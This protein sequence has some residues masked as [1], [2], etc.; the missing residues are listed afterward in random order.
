[1]KMEV[2]GDLEEQVFFTLNGK[3]LGI[4]TACSTRL[5]LSQ[6]R[7]MFALHGRGDSCVINTGR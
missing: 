1:M 7:A 6:F 2:F 3:E 4:A 5:D